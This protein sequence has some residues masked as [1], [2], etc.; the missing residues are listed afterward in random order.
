MVNIRG[1]Y[2]TLILLVA[3]LVS[4]SSGDTGL[5]QSE[6]TFD[7]DRLLEFGGGNLPGS[8][9]EIF[10]M[11]WFRGGLH[12]APVFSPDGNSFWWAGRY[13]T[14]KAYVSHYLNDAWTDQEAV[15]FSDEISSYQDPFISPDGMKFYFVSPKPIPG[16]EESGKENYWMMEWES[17]EWGEPQPLPGTVNNL[18]I[19]WTPSVA[20][21]YDFYFAATIDGNPD[22]FKAEF[23]NGT[24]LNPVPLG[25]PVSTDELEFTPYIAPDQSYLLFSRAANSTSSPFLYISYA[26]DG[27][28]TEPV[29]VEN[30][31]SCVSPIVTPDQKYVIYL[32]NSSMLEWRD[33]SFIEELKP[34]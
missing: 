12:S 7:P 8:E 24:Y 15:S 19:H 29:R 23:K 2:I 6:I 13:S 5:T 16:Q 4:C 1:A 27:G 17:G 14:Q 33:T 28:W 9:P 22:I 18:T 34:D 31:E 26:L 11:G 3:F 32:K 30:V 25:L 20:A 21:N 10:G